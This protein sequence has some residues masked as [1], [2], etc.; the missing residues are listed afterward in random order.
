MPEAA[1]T[2]EQLG[3]ERF[4][5]SSC[6]LAAGRD[7]Q[8]DGRGVQVLLRGGAPAF[9]LRAVL[10]DTWGKERKSHLVLVHPAS[11]LL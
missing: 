6:L 2:E 3:V 4:S 11:S 1:A 10:E 5:F 8:G 9:Q 7:E